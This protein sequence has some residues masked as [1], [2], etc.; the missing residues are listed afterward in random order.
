MGPNSHSTIQVTAMPPSRCP[1]IWLADCLLACLEA[2]AAARCLSLLDPLGTSILP[3]RNRTYTRAYCSLRHFLPFLFLSIPHK[4]LFY[5]CVAATAAASSV[6]FSATP[7]CLSLNS[8]SLSSLLD[9][10]PIT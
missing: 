2:A 3:A 10:F 1:P 9:R 8:H 6:G 5:S 4:C 7:P